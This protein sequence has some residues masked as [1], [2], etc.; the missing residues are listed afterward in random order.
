M[1]DRL[2]TTRRLSVSRL[3]ITDRRQRVHRLPER[4]DDR[5]A[6]FVALLLIP[7]L[8]P[9]QSGDVSKLAAIKPELV[10][11]TTALHG[12]AHDADKRSAYLSDAAGYAKQYQLSDSQHAAL[13]AMDGPAMVKMGVH[14]LVPFLANMHIQ[15]LR[16]AASPA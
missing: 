16:K 4:L 3:P 9:A 7:A 2:P 13:V 11:L 12:L 5:L 1:Q 15:R 6:P 14:P 10:Q 8:A